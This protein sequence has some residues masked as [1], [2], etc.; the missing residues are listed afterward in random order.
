MACDVQDEYQVHR[1]CNTMLYVVSPYM[2]NIYPCY[3]VDD[4][5]LKSPYRTDS[6]PKSCRHGNTKSASSR[7]VVQQ[8]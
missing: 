6:F 2:C 5:T 3:H 4:L 8:A 7:Y 1:H